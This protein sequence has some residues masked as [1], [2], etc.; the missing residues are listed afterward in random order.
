[1]ATFASTDFRVISGMSGRS[2]SGMVG[3]CPLPHTDLFQLMMKIDPSESEPELSEQLV[4]RRWLA[5]TGLRKIHLY[6]PT[7]WL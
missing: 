3:L 1:M 5:S 6:S 7:W 2:K 4:Q